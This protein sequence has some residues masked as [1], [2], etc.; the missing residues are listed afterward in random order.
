MAGGIGRVNVDIR[1]SGTQGSAW[2]RNPPPIWLVVSAGVA[3]L[4][5]LLPL[6]V[7]DCSPAA[8]GLISWWPGDGNANDIAFTNNGTLQGGAVISNAYFS[9]QA[10]FFNGTNAFVQIPNSPSLRPT[11]FTIE[12][13]VQFASLTSTG[14]GAPAGDQY[15]VF[16]QNTR[17]TDFEG[18]DLSKTRVGTNDVFRFIVSSASGQ[19]VSVQSTTTISVGTW[20]H[21][22]AVRGSNFVQ[23]YINSVLEGQTNVSFAQDYG[24]FPLYFG[25]SG[26]AVWDRKLNGILEE[27]SIYDRALSPGEISAIYYAYGWGKCKAPSITLNPQNA[28]LPVGAS[29]TFT[30]AANGV[31]TLSYRWLSNGIPIP[32]ATG[33]SCSLS[34]LQVAGSAD[35]SAVVT[36]TLGSA[37]SAAAT[38]AVYPPPSMIVNVDVGDG[39][40]GVK[41][42]TA[43]LGHDTNDFWNHLLGAGSVANAKTA[44]GNTTPASVTVPYGMNNWLLPQAASG[45]PMRDDY[46]AWTGGI[47]PVTVSD[48]PS[49]NYDFYLYS[50]DGTFQLSV[51]NANYG[52][53]TAFEGFP[54]AN[55]PVW[56]EGRQFVSFHNV[57]VTN[58]GSAVAISVGHFIQPDAIIAGMQIVRN[59][60]WISQQPSNAFVAVGS[61]LLMQV[62]VE[63]SPSTSYQWYFNNNTPLTNGG[64]VTGATS[65]T[66]V[67]ANSQLADAGGYFAVVTNSSGAATSL[68]ATA[69][70]GFPPAF[71]QSPSSQT[72]LAGTTAQFS[73][74]VNSDAP[75][76]LQWLL[77]GSPLVNDAR[78]FGATTTNLTVSSVADLDEGGY[79]LVASN[80]F[81]VV[82]SAVAGLTVL[83]PPIITGQPAN[84]YVLI[85]QP[86]TFS[87][88]STGDLPQSYQWYFG[89]TPLADSGRFGGS[90]SNTL[91]IQKVQ[92]NDVG[93][94]LVVISNAWGSATSIVATLNLPIVRYVN[95]S[96]STPV[97]PYTNW[98]T[99]AT[100]IQLAINI[101]FPNDTILVTNGTYQAGDV[102]PGGSLVP[103]RIALNKP[104]T[105]IS[106][107]GPAVTTILGNDATGFT[108]SAYGRRCAY[109]TDGAILSGFTLSAGRADFHDT[110]PSDQKGGGVL[111]TSASAVVSN[112]VITGNFAGRSGGGAYSGTLK[113]CVVTDNQAVN[114]FIGGIGEGGGAYA[115]FLENCLVSSNRT[116][117]QGGGAHLSTLNN[118]TVVGNSAT[119]AGGVSSSF[120]TNSI[121]YFNSGNAP[122]EANYLNGAFDT[123]CST[124]YPGGVGNT[125]N[126]P[127]FVN[128]TNG[129]FHLQSGSLCVNAGNNASVTSAVDL[130]G[131]PRVVDGVVDL[132]AYEFQHFPFI[133]IPPVSQSVVLTSNVLFTVYALGDAPLTYQWQKDGAGLSDD[134][135]VSGVAAASLSISNLL[136]PDAGSYRVIVANASGSVTSAVAKLTLLGLPS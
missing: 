93:G 36:N 62:G 87:V 136:I 28:T 129:D 81:G 122:A 44:R 50:H 23:L 124:P 79:A 69:R 6:A 82:T 102:W 70:V 30:V 64:H 77:N 91:T 26:Q 131:R 95:V 132:G 15:I 41:T 7:A 39:P 51:G 54:L 99:A 63:A 110:N 114:L 67:I 127:A 89:S 12:C 61:S 18:F 55:P 85:A 84:Q 47:S 68:V 111:C 100:N 13:F 5:A 106:A 2:L 94:Y 126:E 118:C 8:S 83:S 48:L 101:A 88:S 33:Q 133:L 98:A 116:S 112:C 4:M 56:T 31:G 46:L 113:N 123:S 27:V 75:I 29:V 49:G 121:V 119:T 24:N 37:T 66:L 11:N 104:V 32:G 115:S 135:R 73:A 134:A 10:F 72:N 74:S 60:P 107:N 59:S 20:Y 90:T 3:A 71:A 120:T 76:A 109:V 25:T 21:L 34:N 97:S 42:G 1:N 57:L 108:Y 65:N 17:S 38:L 35:Y 128:L 105:V 96:N 58:G 22:A 103:N 125:T 40:F 92:L 19:S 78:H 86:A 16:K 52:A 117:V 53:K 130:D 80:A 14:S 43:A 45:D 9:G